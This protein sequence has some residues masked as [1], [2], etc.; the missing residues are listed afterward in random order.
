MIFLRFALVVED[1]K[2]ATIDLSNALTAKG[3]S[4]QI[5]SCLAE[6]KQKVL[7]H[8]AAGKNFD[9]IV[10][11]FDLAKKIWQKHRFADGYRFA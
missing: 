7:E 6:A 5:A 8:Y 4:V 10:T 2:K 3:F 9:L 1:G 11:D